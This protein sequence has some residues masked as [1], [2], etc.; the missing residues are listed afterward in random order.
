MKEFGWTI[1]YTLS[2]TFPVFLELSLMLRRIRCDSAIDEFYMPYAAVKLGGKCSKRLFEGRGSFMLD[3]GPGA[4]AGEASPE[5][6]NKA[7]EKLRRITE[8][9]QAAIRREASRRRT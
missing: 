1:E 5:Q 7:L 8:E 6:V 9:R 4:S 2:L 3:G